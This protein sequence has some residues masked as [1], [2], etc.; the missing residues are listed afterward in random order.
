MPEPLFPH[1]T[2]RLDLPL[3]FAG[4]SQ[5]EAFVNETFARLDALVHCAIEAPAGAPPAMPQDGQC[6]RVAPGASGAWTGL[7]GTIASY[8]QGQWLFH[9]PRDGLY[10]LDKSTGQRLHYHGSWRAAVKP[11][12]PLGGAVVDVQARTAIGAMVDALVAAGVLPT[13]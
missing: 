13:Q 1:R 11:A 8:Q 2:P 6:W 10:V 5:R 9:H 7:E 12:L 3:L 4:Q